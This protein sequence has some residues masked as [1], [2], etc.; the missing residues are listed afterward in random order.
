M[1]NLSE[2]KSHLE[3]LFKIAYW[4][5]TTSQLKQIANVCTKNTSVD[6]LHAIVTTVCPDTIF[7]SQE[8]IDN[9]DIRTLLALAIQS[10]NT[11][12]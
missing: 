11:Q 8:G 5:P 9:S 10:A 12:N 3:K 2:F 6:D 1:N 4:N 7:V